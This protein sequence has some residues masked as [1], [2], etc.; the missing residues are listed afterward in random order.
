MLTRTLKK[1][2]VFILIIFHLIGWVGMSF[3]DIEV[4]AQ[5]TPINLLLS[6]LLIGVSHRGGKGAF[7]VLLCSTVILGYFVEVLGVH[8]GFPF[9]NYTYGPAMWPKLLDVPVIIGV[10][11]FLM[12]IASGFLA[13]RISKYSWLQVILAAAIM[14]LLDMAI[15]TVAP[16]LDY[17]Y[18][19]DGVVPLMNYLGWFG[20]ALLMQLIFQGT[21]KRH[22][23]KLA[24]PYLITVA[25][26]FTLLNFTL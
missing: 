7:V 4:F 23:N 9:G 15:E 11:W 12:V 17:W 1:Y 2:A 18:W 26:F 16:L 8:T 25:V 6:V 22:T 21:V 3:I 10:N 19:E 13:L 14:V 5:L 24:I 20:V